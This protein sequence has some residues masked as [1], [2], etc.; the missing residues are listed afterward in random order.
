MLW[1]YDFVRPGMTAVDV[2]ANVGFMTLQLQEAVGPSGSV[3]AIEPQADLLPLL[4]D[5]ASHIIQAAVGDTEGETTIYRSRLYEQSSL[6]PVNVPEPL[7]SERVRL[8]TL[9]GLQARGELPPTVD[10]IKVDTQGAE[11]AIWRGASHL[12]ETQRPLWYLELW[13]D[14]L[15]GAGDSIETFRSMADAL[16]YGPVAMDWDE[17]CAQVLRSGGPSSVDAWIVPQERLC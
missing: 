2:G 3:W 4:R 11:A 8:V 1:G 15:L 10:V 17:L 16:G 13:R 7:G 5:R 6:Y 12:L 14:G 9:D